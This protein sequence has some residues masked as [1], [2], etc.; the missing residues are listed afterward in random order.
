MKKKIYSSFI[1]LSLII[2]MA[3]IYFLMPVFS[4]KFYS[5]YIVFII[6]A[7][8]LS[9][10]VS[11]NKGKE[12]SK[13]YAI[14]VILIGLFIIMFIISLPIFRASSYKNLLPAPKYEEFSKNI[15]PIDIKEIPTVNQKYA[16]LLADKKLG[17]ET[18]LGSKVELGTLTLQNVNGKLYYV[19]PLVHSGFMKWLLNDST[20][21][22]ITVSATD[23]KDVKLVTKLNGKD[24]KIRYQ[25]KGF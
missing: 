20:P 2:S 18:S 13:I 14:P 9:I 23:D 4:V 19:A 7:L 21:G 5:F 15:T 12:S 6:I 3:L 17:E 1:V 24:I 25:P 11:L 22:Y 10:N 8:L 16:E